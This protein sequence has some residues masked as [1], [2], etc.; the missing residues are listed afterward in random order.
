MSNDTTTV[1]KPM[2]RRA[3]VTSAAAA[4]AGGGLAVRADAQDMPR[5]AEDDPTAVALKYVHDASAVDAALR[6]GDRFCNNC[7]LYAGSADDE[8]AA[9]SIF[10]GKQVKGQGWCSVWAPKPGA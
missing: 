8:W 9:C 3:F 7:A 2:N 5:L 4:L 10:P 6:P 1:I